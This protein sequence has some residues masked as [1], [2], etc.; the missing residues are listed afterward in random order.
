VKST[1]IVGGAVVSPF[2]NA[3][4]DE[5]PIMYVIIWTKNRIPT[6]IAVFRCDMTAPFREISVPLRR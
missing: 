2:T 5:A 4:M 3:W 1:P 6:A